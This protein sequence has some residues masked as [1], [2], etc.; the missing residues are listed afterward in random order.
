MAQ[1]LDRAGNNTYT[2]RNLHAEFD[3]VAQ[4]SFAAR[5]RRKARRRGWLEP[6]FAGRCAVPKGREALFSFQT[7]ANS[8]MQ[9]EQRS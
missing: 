2:T 5:Y 4:F 9:V 7:V 8:E 3:Y 6:S 1:P